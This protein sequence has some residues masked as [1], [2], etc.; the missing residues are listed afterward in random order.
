MPMK[1]STTSGSSPSAPVSAA[2]RSGLS[3]AGKPKPSTTDPEN[4]ALATRWPPKWSITWPHQVWVGSVTPS[5]W[6]SPS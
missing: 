5:T 3:P 6:T 4:A 1:T 2:T